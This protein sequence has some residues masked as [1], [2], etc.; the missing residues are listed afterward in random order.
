MIV[1]DEGPGIP[2]NQRDKV[3]ERYYQISQG[4]SRAHEGMGIGLTLAKSIMEALDGEVK[5]LEAADGCVVELNLP[6]GK[7]GF[8]S[9]ASNLEA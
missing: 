6:P 2:S 5:I 8:V 3:F 9:A 1:Q 7:N 4:D